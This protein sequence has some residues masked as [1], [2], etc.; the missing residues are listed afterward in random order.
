MSKML[1][2]RIGRLVVGIVAFA[3]I[4][5]AVTWS[6]N[7]YP[8]TTT[9]EPV[10]ASDAG[11]VEKV[12]GSDESRVVLTADAVG[13]LGIKT[14]QVQLTQVGGKQQLAI[15]YGAVLYD[16]DGGAWTYT[17]PEP[18]VY[19]RHKVTVDSIQGDLATLTDGPPAGT[20]VV[21]VGA[22][23]LY[24]TEFGVGGDE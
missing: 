9:E 22:P 12:N 2:T 18:Q 24:G 16:A 6:V 19:V 21:V 14:A 10:A 23:E 5:V 15:P 8:T 4:A 11:K 13:R 3:A 7:A 17:S 1:S 20:T